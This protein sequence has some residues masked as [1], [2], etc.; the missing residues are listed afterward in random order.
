[1]DSEEIDYFECEAAIS[2]SLSLNLESDSEKIKTLQIS[3]REE[4]QNLSVWTGR[5]PVLGCFQKIWL[6]GLAER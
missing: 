4:S 2:G 3:E 6:T 5:S 1:M